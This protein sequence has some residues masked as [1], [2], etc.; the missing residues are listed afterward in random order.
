MKRSSTLTLCLLITLTASAQLQDTLK[1]KT[2]LSQSIADSSYRQFTPRL[3]SYSGKQNYAIITY[4]NIS[5]VSKGY[6][7]SITEKSILELESMESVAL[8]KHDLT[9]LQ[10]LWIKDFSLSNQQG[11]L[12]ESRDQLPRYVVL[13]RLIESVS[14]IDSTMV[15]TA[16]RETYQELNPNGDV[17]AVLQ[18]TFFHTWIR[19][20]GIWKLSTKRHG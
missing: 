11:K 12:S 19:Q 7:Q 17:T 20:N 2:T 6:G 5:V 18:R 15:T 1:S 10:R 13:N 8:K 3:S 16:G 14:E 4:E 9:T